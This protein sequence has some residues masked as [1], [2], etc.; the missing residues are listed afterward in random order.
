MRAIWSGAIAFGLINIPIRVY[1]GS[2]EH[3]LEF[4]MLHK[5]DLS[6]IRFARMCKEDG[7]EVPYSD[8]VKGFEYEKGEYVVV[9]DEDFKAANAK[10]TSTIEI[11]QFTDLA[12]VD[13]IYF[14]KPYFIEPDKKAGK[15]YTLLCEA[16]SESKKVAIASFVFRNREHIGALIALPEG[17]L[18][19]QMRYHQEVRSFQELKI[20]KEKT[21]AKER[22]MAISLI[23]QLTLPFEPEKY[24]DT[25][26]EDLMG[27]IEKKLQGKKVAKP[28]KAAP[29][30]E[31]RDLMHLLQE[32]MKT[33]PPRRPRA[34]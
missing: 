32:S 16:L 2:E 13:P 31:A 24:H 5:K 25:Y 7:K 6:P 10:K 11:K 3:E 21:T 30:Y 9:T 1:P 29:S 28:K 12:N 23:D 20:P 33:K 19:I 18:L 22:E 17:L 4:H 14:E 8:I 15:A 34:R 26:V 27:M